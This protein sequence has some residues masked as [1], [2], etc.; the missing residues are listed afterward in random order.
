MEAGSLMDLDPQHRC[1]NFLQLKVLDPFKRQGYSS[2]F[3]IN[4]IQFEGVP[5]LNGILALFS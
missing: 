2:V 1:D 3:S 5:G 4:Y